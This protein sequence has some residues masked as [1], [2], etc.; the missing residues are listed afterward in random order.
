[1]KMRKILEKRAKELKARL[2]DLEARAT[3]PETT[4]EQLT[5]IEEQVLEITVDI[6]E[7]TEA[8]AA[9]P[10]EEEDEL[11]EEIEDL[12]AAVDDLQAEAAE[13]DTQAIEEN[14][15]DEQARSRI[16]NIIGSGLASRSEKTMKQISKRS[17]F[18]RFLAGRITRSKARSLGVGFNGGKV[19]VPD[20]LNKELIT[21]SQEENPLRKFGRVHP[22]KGTQGFPV[23]VK[24]ADANISQAERDSS[25]LIPET[26]IEF[27]DYFLNPIEI[28]AIIKVTKKLT[29]MSD[30]DIEAI[31][32]DELKKAY[33]RKEAFWYFSSPNNAGSLANKAVK[34]L[35][36]ANTTNKYLKLVQ[37]KNALPTAMRNGA[38]WMINREGQTELESI[39][40][41][42]GNPILK[43]SGNEDFPFTLFTYPVEVT[44]FADKW[45]ATGKVYDPSVPMIYFGNFNYFHIQDVIGSMEI[46]ILDQLYATENKIGY[47]IY[48]LNDG[49]L[50]YGPFEVPV[51]LLDITDD[52]A[53][54]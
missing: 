44:D 33:V 3:D 1:M 42:N 17:A 25:K 30:F 24:K 11:Q 5:E 15:G 31:V 53:G 29:Y 9:L 12:G 13:D 14:T 16:M 41:N 52:N 38:R 36:K 47:K 20:E 45:N 6:D 2:K 26:D 18:L 54:G 46:E 10:T 34:F 40:D 8:I 49:Q 32:L 7:V 35:V 22:T 28:D 51:Y 23:Q 21:Y 4:T 27:D 39:L 37:L 19:L 43:E 48:H 50:V